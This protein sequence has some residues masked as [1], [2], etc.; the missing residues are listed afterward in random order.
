MSSRPGGRFPFD[1]EIPAG[2]GIPC[3]G[4]QSHAGVRNFTY[5]GVIDPDA[6]PH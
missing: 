4:G 1:D 5:L 2:A 3:L 6:R